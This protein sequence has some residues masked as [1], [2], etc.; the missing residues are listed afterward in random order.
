MGESDWIEVNL[1]HAHYEDLTGSGTRDVH[2]SAGGIAAAKFAAQIFAIR[3]V[4]E[5]GAAVDLRLDFEFLTGFNPESR[6]IVRADL[7]VQDIFG[8]FLHAQ[9]P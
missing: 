2:T 7:K 4:I 1:A 3:M 8:S 5:P 9:S 6:F